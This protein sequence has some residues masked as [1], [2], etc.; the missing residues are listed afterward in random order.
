M[1]KIYNVGGGKKNS[2]SLLNLID[3]LSN[4]FKK[5]IKYKIKKK[6]IGDQKYFV[7]DLTKVRKNLFWKPKV[8]T[9]EGIKLFQDW[10]LSSVIN[11]N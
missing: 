3:I 8:S 9:K 10:I 1:K 7:N 5:K 4:V 11:K 2:I 6:R